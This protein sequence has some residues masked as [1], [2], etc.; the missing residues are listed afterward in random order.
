MLKDHLEQLVR[1]GYL[2]K[3]VMGPRNQEAEQG[4]R[5]RRNPLPPLLGVIEV[6]HVT[7]RGT[8]VTRRR[9]ALA[10]VPVE[11]CQDEQPSKKELKFTWEPIAF[12]DEN[13]EGTIQLHDDAL[14][15][16]ARINGFILKRVGRPRKWC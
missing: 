1:V 12:N 4:T 3:S 5:P 16:T 7:S 13:L 11:G 9:G 10:V 14:V 15:V 8:L 6:I 2:K